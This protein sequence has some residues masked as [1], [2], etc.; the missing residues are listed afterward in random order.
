M[1]SRSEEIRAHRFATRRLLG[2]IVGGRAGADT[3]RRTGVGVGLGFLAAV[4]SLGVAAVVAVV[5]PA[6]GQWRR[7][8]AVIVER[9]TGARY[10]YRDSTL[11]PVLNYASA[12]LVLGS[13]TP[14]VVLASRHDL[15]G[16][17]RGAPLGIA[18]APDSL[19]APSDLLT[20][21]WSV[22]SSGAPVS[23]SVVLGAPVAG[24]GLGEG[25]LLVRAGGT[26]YLVWH[27]H[28]ARVDRP[29]VVL[30]GL[31]W[32][33]RVPQ[34]VAPALVNALPAGS[35]LA[36]IV[37]DH[38]GARS[39]VQG[40]PVGTVVTTDNA[41]RTHSYAV[42][43]AGG[44]AALTPVQADIL[45]SDA[46]TPGD[47]SAMRVT[48]RTFAHVTAVLPGMSDWPATTPRLVS[49]ATGVCAVLTSGATGDGTA[50][51][52]ARQ[53]VVGSPAV[54]AG[55][56]PVRVPPGRGALV[57]AAAPAGA[58][59]ASAAECLLTDSGSCFPVADAQALAS[60]GYA[61]AP[62]AVLPAE[63]KALLPGGVTLSRDAAA[64][65]LA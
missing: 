14:P 58:D 20:G 27:G 61:G 38:R 41:Q 48:E 62:V 60:L 6:A 7:S 50:A 54:P 55:M 10:V 43:L 19:P 33:A 22:C 47:G 32:A 45:L 21:G 18:G 23:G 64:R 16:T 40:L 26:D 1:A 11:Y 46:D 59:P 56:P 34:P 44:L 51:Q 36:P 17:A 65:G 29:A 31:G 3:P 5:A 63:V 49:A 35:P 8:D 37:V 42:V 13:P 53:I 4:V 2:A 57:R 39:S 30:A 25:A 24:E 15:A 28:R 9:E 52:P 12:R